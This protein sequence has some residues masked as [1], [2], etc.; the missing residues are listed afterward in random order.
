MKKS[1]KRL[2]I[3][4]VAMLLVAMLAL[5]TA[6][7]AWFTQNTSATADTVHAK[8]VKASTLLISK[9]ASPTATDWATYV[10]YGI[11]SKSGDTIT[12]QTMFPASSGDGANWFTGTSEY[13]EDVVVDSEITHKAGELKT[14]A[15]PVE[16]GSSAPKYVFQSYLHVKNGGDEGDIKNIK[17]TFNMT[18]MSDYARIAIVP[19]EVGGTVASTTLFKDYVYDTEGETYKGLTK[20][21]G[22]DSVSIKGKTTYTVNVGTTKNGNN[23]VLSGG[24]AAYYKLFVWFEGQDKDCYDSKAG[25]V[26]EDLEFTVTGDPV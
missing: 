3:S 5:G 11:G 14:N 25:Q 4:S 9:A 8:T 26:I 21:D 7:F 2:L 22:T 23:Y 24:E 13:A 19:C 10:S 16:P 1:R 17:I 20:A 6:T 12:H 18:G 15:S